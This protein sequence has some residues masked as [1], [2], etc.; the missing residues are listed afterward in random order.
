MGLI[1]LQNEFV[2]ASRNPNDH[3]MESASFVLQ[4]SPT[5]RALASMHAERSCCRDLGARS[6]LAC[7]RL[8]HQAGASA[9]SERLR[10]VRCVA[11]LNTRHIDWTWKQVYTS[12]DKLHSRSSLPQSAQAEDTRTFARMQSCSAVACQ[13]IML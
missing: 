10:L 1:H 4:R 8:C 3:R 5:D 11:N 7:R 13:P 12:Q 9:V 2:N 6:L